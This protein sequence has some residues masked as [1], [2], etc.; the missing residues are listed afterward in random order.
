[1]QDS[2]AEPTESLLRLLVIT[3]GLW[4]ERIAENIAAHAPSDWAV[5]SWKAPRVLPPVI[6]DPEELIPSNLPSSDLILALGEVAG[7][8]Q[9]APEIARKTGAR[10]VIAPIDRNE[11]LPPGLVAQLQG[12]LG[13]LGVASVFPKPFCSLTETSCN[14]TPLV[15][16]Y[17]DPTIRRFARQF[18]RP[19]F[20]AS[21]E[22]QHIR[23]LEVIRDA[24]CGCARHVAEGLAGC[25][26]DRAV[27]AAGML[28]HHFPCLA[29]M[30]KDPDY[31][32]TLMHV[33]GHFLQDAVK[34][35]IRACLTP[36]AYLR[37]SN[38]AD[39]EPA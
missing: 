14:R 25:H 35:E 28:H 16:T 2:G 34:E 18:G 19:Q 15:G 8:A 4:G 12:W 26:V 9:L 13:E 39:Q 3:Q 6:D 30:N 36:V 22:G 32:D 33:S 21:V 29:S 31:L 23:H 20:R 38:L 5:E 24:A 37:P 11:S 7:V 10:A 1:M 17:D 27:E